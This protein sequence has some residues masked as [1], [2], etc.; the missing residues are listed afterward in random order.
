[1]VRVG[2]AADVR[3]T[4]S[5]H[6]RG[7]GPRVHTTLSARSTFSPHAW[8]W[9]ALVQGIIRDV[10]V[11]PTRVGMVR[12]GPV[13]APPRHGSPH[14]RGDGPAPVTFTKPLARFS[15]HA[16]GWSAQAG[17]VGLP[18]IVLPTR[19]GMVR[20]RVR[21]PQPLRR[22]PHTRG[23]GPISWGREAPYEMFSPHAWGW[24]GNFTRTIL[25]WQIR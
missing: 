4:S 17:R 18:R 3:A 16:W 25:P 12:A 5:P 7:D 13:P 9:S 23:D 21:G 15:P 1:M 8:G 2:A 14:T 10:G 6:T 19:V 24:S 20:R 22:S 11:L